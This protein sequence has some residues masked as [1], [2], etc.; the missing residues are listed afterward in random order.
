MNPGTDD[1][2]VEYA[3]IVLLHLA[4]DIQRTEQIFGIVPSSHGHYGGLNFLQM[5]AEVARLPVIVVGPVFHHLI[6][7]RNSAFEVLFIRIGERTETQVKVV[8]IRGLEIERLRLLPRGFIEPLFENTQKTKSM[9][10]VKR[11]VVVKI[12]ANKPI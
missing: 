1:Q 12:I 4:I 8:T 10:Q 7:I 6:P 11:A 2:Y 9:R 5:R 3:G